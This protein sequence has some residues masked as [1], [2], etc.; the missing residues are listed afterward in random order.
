MKHVRKKLGVVAAAFLAIASIAHGTTEGVKVKLSA[1]N[2]FKEGSANV[3]VSQ[4]RVVNSLGTA[5]SDVTVSAASGSALTVIPSVFTIDYLAAGASVVLDDTV[6]VVTP[7]FTGQEQPEGLELEWDITATVIAPEGAPMVAMVEPAVAPVTLAP[8]DLIFCIDSTGSMWDDIGAV[9]AAA[10]EIITQIATDIPEFRIAVVDYRD[11][12]VS[13]YGGSTDYEYRDVLPFTTDQ[14]AAV[15]AINSIGT[16]GGADWPE[17]AYAALMHCIDSTSLGGW[18]PEGMS[19]RVMIIM[20]DAP[21]HDPEPFTGYVANDVCLAALEAGASILYPVIIGG[22]SS[23]A[24]YFQA[25]ADCTG[26]EV[27]TAANASAVVA[28][29]KAALEEISY[30]PV[31]NAGG[32]YIGDPGQAIV[33]DASASFDP[34]GVIVLF[35]WDWDADGVYDEATGVP[36]AT[37]SWPAE[38]TGIVRVR[39]MDN[40]GRTSVGA[41]DVTVADHTPPQILSADAIPNPAMVGETVTFSV[42]AIDSYDPT[43][44]V[45]WDF[46]DG[47][48]ATT[49]TT[50]AYAAA[51]TYKATVTVTD[52][53]GNSTSLAVTVVVSDIRAGF[54]FG[55]GCITSPKGAYSANGS[56]NGEARFV[57]YSKY[58]D[59]ETIPV[60]RAGFNLQAG[61]LK[62][63]SDNYEALVVSP[64]GKNAQISGEGTANG[65]PGYKF[66]VWMG[67][68]TADT[69][70]IRIWKEDVTGAETT[71]YDNGS[72]LPIWKGGI[73]ISKENNPEKWW[74]NL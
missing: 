65:K 69:F 36:T 64:D 10:N 28:A 45:V 11:F 44:D 53:A 15:A 31:V 17:S 73:V 35:E 7:E 26:G 29:I 66:M 59:G 67:D 42:D 40:D 57:V 56:I 4:V 50:H 39:A 16:G 22:D 60:G 23:A 6:A 49:D 2:T 71:I 20:T 12:P 43:L 21:P 72:M 63:A 14:A 33:F 18:R 68:D 9:K 62:F 51:G 37:H 30:S 5:V 55:W 58:N 48:P 24:A 8:V 25:L 19:K 54:A 47:S 41:A 70:R 13:P 1:V 34:D 32:P 3:M 38:Y 52:D 74:L 27:F 46:G 61:S